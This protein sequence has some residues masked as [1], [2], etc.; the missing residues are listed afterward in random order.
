MNKWD[1]YFLDV[2][3]LTAG[4]SKDPSTG[5][6][7]VIVTPDNQLVSTGFNGFPR[8]IEDT[9]ER[10]NNRE[11]KLR[12]VVHAE[13]NSMLFAAR[14]GIKIDG[15][16]MYICATDSSGKIWGGAPCDQC[17]K[18]II[19]SGIKKIISY[20]KKSIPTKWAESLRLSEE[21]LKEAGIEYVEVV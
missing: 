11:E 21:L 7:S 19:Q 9:K 18:H 1:K 10:L 14:I 20:P 12:L 15:Y 3:L 5:V 4:L 16:T 13:L 2:A 17:C 8:G 6:G